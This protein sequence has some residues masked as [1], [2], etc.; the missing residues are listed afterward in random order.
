MYHLHHYRVVDI[1]SQL[2]GLN[3]DIVYFDSQQFLEMVFRISAYKSGGVHPGAR[4][5]YT[6][7]SGSAD[8]C[9]AERSGRAAAGAPGRGRGRAAS[10]VSAV[11]DILPAPLLTNYLQLHRNCCYNILYAQKIKSVNF[12]RT[13]NAYTFLSAN[14]WR[15]FVFVFYLHVGILFYTFSCFPKCRLEYQIY[16]NINNSQKDFH[17]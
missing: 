16:R 17:K 2:N 12:V 8:R 3:Q 9:G 13:Y 14:N 1:H 6:A 10:A 4:R 11:S 15:L 7:R 5:R